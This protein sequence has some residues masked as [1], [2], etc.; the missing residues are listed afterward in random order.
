MRNGTASIDAL[1]RRAPTIAAWSPEALQLEQVTCVQVIAELRR[2]EPGSMLPPGLHPTDPPSLSI[3]AMTVGDSPWGPFSWV[4]ARLSCRSGVRA[5]G[6]ATA[7]VASTATAADGLSRRAGFPC[8]V[9]RI[10]LS[11]HYDGVDLTV[12][13]TLRVQGV[14]AR[15]L[16]VD[17]VQYTGTMN[18]AHTPQGLRLVQV[19][20]QHH[21]SQVQRVRARIDRFVPGAWGDDRLDPYFVV[22]ATVAQETSVVIPALRFVC[23][24]E[25]SAF[26][27]TQKITAEKITAE[28]ITAG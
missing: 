25:V 10:A 17:D 16:G 18:L 4:L 21:V 5:R 19:E 14:D 26:E 8:R 27:G 13:D 15:P 12:D 6:F 7:A 23:R 9:G 2:D 3:Q 1:A 24:P 11:V 28:K 20:S 22:S